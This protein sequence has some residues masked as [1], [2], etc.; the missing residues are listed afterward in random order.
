MTLVYLIEDDPTMANV[1]SISIRQAGQ[2]QPDGTI[3]A[4]R[5]DIFMMQFR[6]LRPLTSGFPM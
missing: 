2:L 1:L 3:A 4:P 6:L 5:V